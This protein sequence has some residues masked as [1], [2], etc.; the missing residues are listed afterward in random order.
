MQY[1]SRRT[2][3]NTRYTSEEVMSRIDELEDMLS[4]T[5]NS[6]TIDELVFWKKL[7]TVGKK[8]ND[9]WYYGEVDVISE[10]VFDDVMKLVL[11][12]ECEILFEHAEEYDVI[13]DIDGTVNKWK[14]TRFA[15]F[16]GDDKSVWYIKKTCE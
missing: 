6:E 14:N 9:E 12:E 15:K 8:A 5:A 11:L 2:N 7:K 10:K 16:T 3:M 1:R 13:I 4:A